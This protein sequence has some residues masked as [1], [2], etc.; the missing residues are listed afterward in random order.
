[1]NQN[2][3]PTA[4]DEALRVAVRAEIAAAFDGCFPAG[5]TLEV[6]DRRVN[7]GGCVEDV[8]AAQRIEKAAAV[9]AG[10]LGVHNGLSLRQQPAPVPPGQPASSGMNADPSRRAEGQVNHKV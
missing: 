4:E 1:M 6:S 9:S 10:V 8:D 7:L 3:S 2:T 5:V